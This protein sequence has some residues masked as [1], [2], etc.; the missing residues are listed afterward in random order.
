MLKKQPMLRR[1]LT[2]LFLFSLIIAV[3]SGC[4]P[5]GDEI[6]NAVKQGHLLG[7]EGTTVV[8]ALD[9]FF[10]SRN[11]TYTWS[12]VRYLEKDYYSVD[13]NVN[14][15][16][17][18]PMFLATIDG[19]QV[20]LS[21]FY[22][23]FWYNIKSERIA[24]IMISGTLADFVPG[25]E[26]TGATLDGER[27]EAFFFTEGFRNS[28]IILD[29]IYSNEAVPISTLKED[30]VITPDSQI[31]NSSNNTIELAQ[32][33]GQTSDDVIQ[34]LG[35][36]MRVMNMPEGYEV[37]SFGTQ[38]GPEGYPAN[39]NIYDN[40]VFQVMI[41][42]D[43]K[44]EFSL[45][46]TEC[47]TNFVEAGIK[48][49]NLGLVFIYVDE[50]F[51]ADGVFVSFLGEINGI[52]ITIIIHAFL[53][54]TNYPNLNFT[55]SGGD[56]FGITLSDIDALEDIIVGNRSSGSSSNNSD[57]NAKSILTIGGSVTQE[58]IEAF[59]QAR[60]PNAITIGA[61]YSATYPVDHNTLEWLEGYV[62][63][64]ATSN[65]LVHYFVSTEG[66]VF[67]LPSSG[68]AVEIW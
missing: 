30:E 4:G 48:L 47:L 43:I 20:T 65:G 21:Q 60:Y 5:S 32:L 45:L 58:N 14:T 37:W 34:L 17:D 36:P 62:V 27:D 67:S 10:G 23:T 39:I 55:I 59:F 52:E 12:R 18:S 56:I 51:H 22:I 2:L 64:V 61:Q 1:I 68:G 7:Y 44:N 35:Q 46:G 19:H 13:A 8:D 29:A 26:L 24:N 11:T 41:L 31:S 16:R 66:R 25:G 63:A 33:I 53:S 42:V 50:E 15:N 57:S 6:L 28:R 9:D 38:M 54:D 3:V 49:E 40:R